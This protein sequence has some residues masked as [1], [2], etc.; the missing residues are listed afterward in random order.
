MS[1]AF[2]FLRACCGN[3][4][5]S[6]AEVREEPEEE[7]EREAQN[8]AGDD[9]EIESGVLATID[10]VTGEAA[11]TEGEF[12]AEVKKRTNDD[13]EPSEDKKCAAEFSDRLHSEHSS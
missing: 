10:K 9:R 4:L 6:T 11:K 7:R 13:E 12:A 3:G 2:L 1:P 5:P 8:E